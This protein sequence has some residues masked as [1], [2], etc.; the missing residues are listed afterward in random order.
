MKSKMAKPLGVSTASKHRS[1]NI[2]VCVPPGLQTAYGGREDFRMPLGKLEVS[3]G[4]ARATELR[5]RKNVES[6]AKRK[7]IKDA[8]ILVDVPS[9]S[10]ELSGAIAKGLYAAGMAQDD[11]LRDTPGGAALLRDV[12]AITRPRGLTIPALCARE[13]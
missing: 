12:V 13:G 7:A 6:A 9:V 11:A 3:A 2:R 8:T 4:R 1:A 5:A 10:R